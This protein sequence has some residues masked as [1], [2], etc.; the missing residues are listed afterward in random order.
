MAVEEGEREGERGNACLTS[1]GIHLSI[2]ALPYCV[3]V[4]VR[5]YL[6]SECEEFSE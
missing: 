4:C 1:K 2:K 5:N 6:W 3:C